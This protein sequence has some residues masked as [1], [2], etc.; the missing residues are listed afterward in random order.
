MTEQC[1][2]LY[3]HEINESLIPRFPPR[4][5][6]L[7][8]LR[9]FSASERLAAPRHLSLL[10]PALTYPFILPVAIWGNHLL[11]NALNLGP[12]LRILS[13]VSA[14][15]D[16]CTGVFYCV[17]FVFPYTFPRVF[18]ESCS[19][20][21]FCVLKFAVCLS[22]W[23]R[24]LRRRS[25][26]ARLLRLWVRMPSGTWMSVVSVVCCQV[27]V[28][29]T[30]WSLV[31]RSPTVCLV[32]LCVIKKKQKPREWGGGQDPLGGLSRQDKNLLFLLV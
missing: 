10:F 28:S 22:Q 6:L 1:D 23:P 9:R 18:E 19:Y 2:V 29:A 24:G 16:F 31:Q 26:A 11:Y 8:L 20:I 15:T 7:Q 21:L 14:S 3:P 27:E 12:G 25:T 4:L 32:S 30:S 13:Y 17:W 5:L